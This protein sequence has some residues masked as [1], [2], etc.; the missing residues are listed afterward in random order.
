MSDAVQLF[1]VLIIGGGPAGSALAYALKDSG[2]SIAILDKK[3]FPRS[4]VCAGWVSP[5]VMRLLA[6]DL[7]DYAK[8]RVLQEIHGFRLGLSGQGTQRVV[9]PGKPV[10]YAIRRIEFDHYL[11][12]RCTAQILDAKP[13]RDMQREVGGGWLVNKQYRARLIVGAGGHF[14]PVARLLNANLAIELTVVAQE[15]EFEMNAQQQACCRISK[16]IPELFFS[17]DLLGYGWVL[18]KGNYLNIG[19]GREDRHELSVHVQAFFDDLLAQGKI[20]SG[21]E[22]HFSGHAYLLYPHANRSIVDDGRLLIGDAAGLA[23]ARSGEGIRPAVESA[24]LAASVIKRCNGDY[25]SN[26]LQPFQRQ[27]ESRFGRRATG[28]GRAVKLPQ[29]FKKIVARQLFRSP[30]F[31]KHVVIDNWFLQSRQKRLKAVIE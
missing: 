3:Q 18:R 31:V 26:N 22:G 12:Q 16:D 2:L 28:S 25:A 29:R 13:L 21:I 20:P 1:D 11:L 5:E 9:Y 15:M 8:G 23:Y 17:D 19:L 4:K 24:L 10:S 14:C 27:I 6:I 30:W 7:H